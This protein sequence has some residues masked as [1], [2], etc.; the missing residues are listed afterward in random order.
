MNLILAVIIQ[1]FQEVVSEKLINK[2]FDDD[3]DDQAEF[4]MDNSSK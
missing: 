3:D 1:S 2:F 4:K